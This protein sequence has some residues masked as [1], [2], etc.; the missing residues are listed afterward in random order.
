M[1]SQMP[2]DLLLW[3]FL[4]FSLLNSL[5]CYE[6]LI[7]CIPRVVDFFEF[8]ASLVNFMHDLCS[9]DFLKKQCFCKKI[10]LLFLFMKEK[11]LGN[12]QRNRQRKKD[13][14]VQQSANSGR[15]SVWTSMKMS[16]CFLEEKSS[17]PTCLHDNQRG[18]FNFC[19]STNLLAQQSIWSFQLFE[20]QICLYN[21]QPEVFNFWSINLFAQQSTWSF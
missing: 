14:L 6:F 15:I 11:I 21:N 18:V 17:Q 4:F 1:L 9:R 20:A 8:H 10:L 13:Q 7:E 19:R 12:Q 16:F 5:M 3:T 2:C